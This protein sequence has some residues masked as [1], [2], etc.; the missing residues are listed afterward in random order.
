[1]K[2]PEFLNKGKKSPLPQITKRLVYDSFFTSVKVPEL[3]G[4]S[5]G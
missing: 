3:A 4:T 2:F 5:T 1:V